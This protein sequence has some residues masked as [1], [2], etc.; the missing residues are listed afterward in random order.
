MGA[1]LN[2]TDRTRGNTK[3]GLVAHTAATFS[4]LTLGNAMSLDLNSTSYIDNRG[5]PGS[6]IYPPGPYGYQ[7]LTYYKVNTVIPNIM[8]FLNTCLTDGFLVSCVPK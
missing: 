7:W 8:F 1:L 5:F 6:R 2:P 3:W 4:V